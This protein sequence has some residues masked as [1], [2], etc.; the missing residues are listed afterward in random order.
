MPSKRIFGIME[1]AWIDFTADEGYRFNKFD[2]L[3]TSED[4]GDL[5]EVLHSV[6]D[7]SN[8]PAVMTPLALVANPD[9]VK[10]R[11]SG[12]LEYHYESFQETLLKYPGCENSFNLWKEGIRNRLFVPQF[13]GREHLNVNVWL[14]ALRDADKSVTI[15]FDNQM[16]G[17]STASNSKI[18][19]ELQ[20]AFDFL[21]PAD[22]EYHK[23]VISTGLNLFEQLFGY[24][25]SYFVPPNGPFSSSLEKL[26]AMEGISY[27][28]ASKIQAEPLGYG[29]VKKRVNWLGKRTS[30]GLTIL[31]RNCFFE[32]GQSDIDWVDSCLKDVSIAFRWHKPAVISTHRVNYMGSLDKSNREIGLRNLGIL[33][34]RILHNWPD[35]MFVTS[36]ELGDI[37]TNGKSFQKY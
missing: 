28:I 37:I 25:A 8:R 2:S 17:I 3:E 35:T 36:E 18:G 1:K 14:R 23:N 26:C 6:R 15:A 20:A 27:L 5:F 16:W 12:F 32:P 4:L 22:L 34:K 7:S 33:L 29:K 11:N 13:H 31:I 19:I 9:F 10:I 30:D 21:N 24:R